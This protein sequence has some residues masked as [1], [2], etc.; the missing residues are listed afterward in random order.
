MLTFTNR[1]ACLSEH[2]YTKMP[3]EG[4]AKTP[5]LI[6]ANLQAAPLINLDPTSFSHPDF[7]KYF[8]GTRLLPG[9][10]P[11]AMV[12]AGH[13]FGTYVPQL[14]DGRAILL[15]QVLNQQGELWDIQLKGSGKTPYSRFGDGRAVM[16]S[17]IREYLCSEA[18]HGLGIPTTR[19]L[20]IIATDE[21]VMRETLEPGAI[22]TRLALSHIR[23]GHFEYFH[24]TNQHEAVKE[25]ADYVIKEHFP[26][27]TTETF[28]YHK[29]LQEIVER[30]ASLIAA[31]Q[32]VGFAHGVMNT[33]N[34]SI[35]GLTLD[36]GPFGFMDA[37]NPAF[38]CNHSDYTGRYSYQQQP[39]IGLWNLY[40]LA[41]AM[42]S[43]VP[44]EDA[45]NILQLYEPK[46]HQEYQSHMFRKLGLTQQEPEDTLLW[47]TLLQLMITYQSD[48]TLT[49]RSLSTLETF[50]EQWLS[51]FSNAS[52]AEQWRQ[53]YIARLM[54]E[55]VSKD[56]IQKRL[57]TA[58]PKYILR[59]WVAETAIRAAENCQ[60]YSLLDQLLTILHQPFDEHP[61]YEEYA[62]PPPENFRQLQVSCSS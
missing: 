40:A 34:M 21:P 50:P 1:F 26:Y 48:Y 8:S 35:L 25:L 37:F 51:L 16:R 62:S 42:V 13:Q 5:R 9:S 52:E 14:G 19:S 59:N 27:L 22:F 56:E 44:R 29:L 12:Y 47:Q 38:I 39:T 2:F 24:Y 46:F 54:R 55:P 53:R 58:N 57:L 28:P 6:H 60:D 7:A 43:L 17:C 36:Y 10:E 31:W 3:P 18:M 41:S 45:L 33:D 61:F 49:F 32:A 11:L 15:G 30:T 4:F 20:C 23:F